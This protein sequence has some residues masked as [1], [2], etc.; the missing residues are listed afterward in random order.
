M[1]TPYAD[2]RHNFIASLYRL[3]YGLD[4]PNPA[5]ASHSR[6]ALAEL[7]RGMAGG[8]HQ[9]DAFQYL[10]DHD[11]PESEQDTWL[12]VASLFA[13]NPSAR[14]ATKRATLATAMGRLAR[15]RGPA[16]TRRFTQLLA[17]DVHALP[18]HL[19]QCVRLLASGSTALNYETLLDDLV[20][21][22]NARSNPD[23]AHR[24]R[25]RWTRDYHKAARASSDESRTEADTSQTQKPSGAEQPLGTTSD[26]IHHTSTAPTETRP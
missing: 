17:Q 12:L 19:R 20:V 26:S 23:D 21:L 25:L 7:R 10:V 13:L 6:R 2:R 1:S 24:I 22:T 4:S 9:Y 14:P 3:G 11:P 8:R 5:V 15:Q 16:V 18:H